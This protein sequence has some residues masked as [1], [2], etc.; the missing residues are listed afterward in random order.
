[1]HYACMVAVPDGPPQRGH[2]P[3]RMPDVV[4]LLE[5]YIATTVGTSGLQS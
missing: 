2:S 3:A 4:H 1:M 5:A